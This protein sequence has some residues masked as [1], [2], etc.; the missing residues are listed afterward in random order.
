MLRRKLLFF[1]LVIAIALSACTPAVTPTDAGAPTRTRTPKPAATVEAAT[2]LGV[3]EEALRG[4]KIE[5]WH[6]WFAGVEASLF[7]SQVQS[8]N[9]ENPWGI[10]V[11]VRGQVSYS[12]LYENVTAAL[13]TP[14]RPDLV[15]AL[16][17][18]ARA[19]DADDYVVDLSPY[20]DDPL[21]GWTADD[22]SDFPAAFW[23][24]DLAGAARLGV[25]A[26]RTARLVLWNKT[27]ADELG[28]SNAPDVPED[29][30]EQ[31]CRAHQ[32]M[33]A[34]ATPDNDGLGGW[35]IDAD[36][37]TAL[38]WLLAF[39]G[40]VLEGEGYRF[41]TPNNIQAF[42][43]VKALQQEGC[44][45]QAPPA[46]DVLQAFAERKAL[47]ATAGLEEFPDLMRAF[48][49]ADNRDKWEVL[50][51][52]GDSQDVLVAYGSTYVVLESNDEE[53]LASWLFL[54]WMLEPQSDARWV[55]TTGLFPLRTSSLDLL[56]DYEASHP[57]WAQAVEL[58][59][60]LQIQPQLAS[61][62]TVRIMLGDG[63]DCLFRGSPQCEQAPLVLRQM[64]SI[65][66][67]LTD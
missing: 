5:V 64:E 42:R 31:A 59:P 53:Q 41:L 18:H 49:A 24:Q 21:Y 20:V 44:A 12:Y 63:F 39:E 38:S 27:W 57:Q 28:L 22:T 66:A 54:R 40:G 33:L 37:M 17:E 25:P 34:D 6:P 61:W 3:E 35:V 65:A 48:A 52:P 2:L 51:F 29:F 46:V 47:F 58:T 30:K 43:F 36:A 13:P 1:L 19:W 62:R 50:A 26:Q 16:P 60:Q 23:A 7:E 67:D 15:I 56:A 32:A 9:A 8:F 14:R 10:E 55:E 4:L 11:M 45:W